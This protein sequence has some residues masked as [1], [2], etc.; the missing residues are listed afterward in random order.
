MR[1][2]EAIVRAAVCLASDEAKS[3]TGVKLVIERGY[4]A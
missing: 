4:N 2:P 3:G 1:D